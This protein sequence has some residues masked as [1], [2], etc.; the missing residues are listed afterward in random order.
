MNRE[1]AKR[2][3]ESAHEVGLQAGKSVECQ[4]MVVAGGGKGYIVPDGPCG[5]AYVNIKPANSNV[6]K[7]M[8]EI[9]GARKSDYYGGVLLSVHEFNQSVTRK[10]AY[11]RAF[12][13]VLLKSGVKKVYS[14]SRLD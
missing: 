8:I 14:W 11:A 5:F 2:L 13:K 12:A 6:A 7:A 10:G 3:V 4:T 1:K 9:L